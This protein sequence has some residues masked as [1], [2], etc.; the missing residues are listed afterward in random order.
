MTELINDFIDNKTGGSLYYP[1]QPKRVPLLDW[2][3]FLKYGPDTT[4]NSLMLHMDSNM[5]TINITL[6]DDFTGGGLFYLKP[7]WYKDLLYPDVPT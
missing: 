1:D 2:V 6:N 5:H 4:R 7:L 3:F